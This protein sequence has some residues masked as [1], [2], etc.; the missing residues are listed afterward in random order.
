M[1]PILSCG[2]RHFHPPALTRSGA[3]WE[4]LSVPRVIVGTVR[5]DADMPDRL[6]QGI[7]S[8][9]AAD[10]PGGPGAQPQGRLPRPAPGLPHR[11]HR[12]VRVRQV[13]AGVRHDLR[14]GPAPLRRV[15]LG[16]R[17][18]VPRPDGQAR[19]RL[20]RGPLARGLDRPE[21][22]VEEPP[23]HRRHDHRGLRLP[24]P[25]L[26]PRRPAALPD[27]R[28]ADRAAD[29]AA[30]RRPGPRARGGPPLPGPRAG[31]PRP[32][33]RVRRALPPAADPGLLAGPRRR[34]DPH[35]RRPARSWT[36]RRS[37]PSRSWSTGSR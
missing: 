8:G 30:D 4:T 37:T 22:H 9:G 24:P 20:H 32:Q 29:P 11:L 36:S 3:R 35:A 33:G 6:C 15:A 1:G 21:V 26:R 5:I 2:V 17:P 25:A 14:R 18:P 12:P 19:R 31:D 23:L 27:L 16:V 13:L 10:H 34:R 28:G 7:A